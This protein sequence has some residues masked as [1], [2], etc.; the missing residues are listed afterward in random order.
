MCR[1]F[2]RIV[3][4]TIA[5]L[6]SLGTCNV[7][8][9]S[10]RVN[11]AAQKAFSISWQKRLSKST[12]RVC[13][14]GAQYSFWRSNKFHFLYVWPRGLHFW[15]KSRIIS[16]SFW[17][18]L[19]CESLDGYVTTPR[20]I[21]GF[22]KCKAWLFVHKVCFTWQEHVRTTKADKPRFFSAKK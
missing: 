14:P 5:L 2:N 22:G 8:I 1:A 18:C 21:H 6:I 16:K 19:F 13:V 15:R 9:Q 7:G 12:M 4:K 3:G 11:F 10:V 17:R 20:S